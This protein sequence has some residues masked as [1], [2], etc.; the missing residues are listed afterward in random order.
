[1]LVRIAPT[2]VVIGPAGVGANHQKLPTLAH[3]AVPYPG[4]DHDH[5]AGPHRHLSAS[6]TAEYHA[7]LARS[8]AQHLMRD[9]VE[10]VIGEDAVAPGIGPTIPGKGLLHGN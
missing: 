2:N 9:T 7:H 4:R 3:V 10:V 5:I 6:W 8:D 1:M